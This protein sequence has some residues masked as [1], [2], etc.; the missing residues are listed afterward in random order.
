MVSEDQRNSSFGSKIQES[1]KTIQVLEPPQMKRR[2]V[3]LADCVNSSPPLISRNF[4]GFGGISAKSRNFEKFLGNSVGLCMPLNMNSVGNLSVSVL[5]PPE[6]KHRRVNKAY[7][8]VWLRNIL[9]KF[10]APKS[11]ERKRSSSAI[12]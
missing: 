10:A 8:G 6:I 12:L 2:R 7:E 3:K 9:Q 1:L 5:E 4:R 11:A